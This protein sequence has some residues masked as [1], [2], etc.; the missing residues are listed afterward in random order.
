MT[1]KLLLSCVIGSILEWY[2]FALFGVLSPFLSKLF[3]PHKSTTEAL[4]Y[5]FGFF[6]VAYLARPLGG[7]VFG[8]IGDKHGR[9][10]AVIISI[11]LM[12][13]GTTGVGLLP[14]KSTDNLTLLALFLTFRIMQGLS[15]GGEMPGAAVLV[16]ETWQKNKHLFFRLSFLYT[17]VIGGLLLG[18]LIG[19]QALKLSTT[20]SS[21]W[22]FPFLASILLGGVG[23]YLRLNALDSPVFRKMIH[24]KKNIT[25]PLII[26][27][28]KHYRVVI[29]ASLVISPLSV[30][31]YYCFFYYPAYLSSSLDYKFLK[32]LNMSTISLLTLLLIS[33]LL[34]LLLNKKNMAKTIKLVLLSFILIPLPITWLIIHYYT[35]L[36]VE[37]QL[38]YVLMIAP[39]SPFIVGFMALLFPGDIR[40]TG[41]VVAIALANIIGGVSPFVCALLMQLLH[42]ELA[43]VSFVS[44]L[45]LLGYISMCLTVQGKAMRSVAK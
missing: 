37:A 24:D 41:V 33:P 16:V 12:T 28:K 8:H 34:G 38:L 35:F 29:L 43:P 14:T 11:F 39:V 21:A 18:T 30:A 10:K 17:G 40:F 31:F 15:V 42:S 26:V 1:A 22:R 4:L 13:I 36:A 20:Y 7:V 23:I 19:A 25:L 9:K 2:D 3:F 27:L 32:T 44:S 6:A 45:A 5:T